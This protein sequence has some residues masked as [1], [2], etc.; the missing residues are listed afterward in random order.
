MRTQ[1]IKAREIVK[2]DLVLTPLVSSPNIIF[3]SYVYDVMEYD[4]QIYLRTDD[5]DYRF[6]LDQIVTVIRDEV[7]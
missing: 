7:E 1:H 3:A 2:A 5:H 4:E 6:G